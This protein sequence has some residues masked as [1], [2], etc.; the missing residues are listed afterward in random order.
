MYVIPKLIKKW[1]DL[2]D[3]LK[4]NSIIKI[5]WQMTDVPANIPPKADSQTKIQKDVNN[6]I[7]IIHYILFLESN[8]NQFSCRLLELIQE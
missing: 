2:H 6:F 7:K 3:T 1:S 8:K 5:A 4:K